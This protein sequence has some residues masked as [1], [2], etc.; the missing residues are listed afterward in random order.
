MSRSAALLTQI[1]VMA[2]LILAMKVAAHLPRLS[3]QLVTA[4]GRMAGSSS[5]A[6]SCR[7]GPAPRQHQYTAARG[8][9][10]MV[11]AS[12]GIEWLE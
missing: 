1:P 2:A 4:G 12:I 7:S 10:T 11:G 5:E 3:W 6:S 8:S 9:V